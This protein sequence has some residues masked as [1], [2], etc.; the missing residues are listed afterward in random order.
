MYHS[1]MHGTYTEPVLLI[2]M[3]KLA[4]RAENK[5]VNVV[6]F[7]GINQDSEEMAGSFEARLLCRGAV[8]DFTVKCTGATCLKDTSYMDH[9]VS[10]QLVR[11][12]ADTEI[13]E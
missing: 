11:G 13:Q 6:S 7:L 12:L 3:E 4:V 9:M 2:A 8:C 5:L 1:G 10:H